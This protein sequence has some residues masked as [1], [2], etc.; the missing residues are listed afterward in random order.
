MHGMRI[1]WDNICNMLNAQ[2]I[3]NAQ[4]VLLC[5]STICMFI[6]TPEGLSDL[7]KVTWLLRDNVKFKT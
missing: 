2:Y 1:K 3:V 5:L 7:L 4:L 6:L